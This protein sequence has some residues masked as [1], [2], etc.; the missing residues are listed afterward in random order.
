MNELI[1]C[2]DCRWSGQCS[3]TGA[4]R[5]HR[6]APLAS[7]K[8]VSDSD[9]RNEAWRSF[10]NSEPAPSHRDCFHAGWVAGKGYE[11]GAGE[12]VVQLHNRPEVMNPPASAAEGA[13]ARNLDKGQRHGLGASPR[14]AETRPVEAAPLPWLDGRPRDS[15]TG[16][17]LCQNVATPFAPRP[18]CH[19]M[20]CN[21]ARSAVK[22]TPSLEMTQAEW[23]RAG[24]PDPAGLCE[25]GIPRKYCTAVHE[26][27][28]LA[29]K[30]HFSSPL[31]C[32]C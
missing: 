15:Q 4:C 23:D 16:R 11:R 10:A 12:T 13:E 32:C 18:G 8:C 24:F 19:C 3:K 30:P 22:T 29:G 6:P 5:L 31:S 2:R 14:A 9:A 28:K 20:A 27:G 26:E 25:H 1:H 21:D 17:L 7:K